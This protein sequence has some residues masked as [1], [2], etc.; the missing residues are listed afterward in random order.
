MEYYFSNPARRSP[1]AQSGRDEESLGQIEVAVLLS[2]KNSAKKMGIR[3]MADT[4]PTELVI[5]TYSSLSKNSRL[6][7]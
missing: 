3:R 6:L 7:C 1:V 2:V 5:L 4:P